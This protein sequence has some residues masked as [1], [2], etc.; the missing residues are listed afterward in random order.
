MTAKLD[1][2]IRA[3]LWHE[4]FCAERSSLKIP[5][6]LLSGISDESFYSE[7][8]DAFSSWSLGLLQPQGHFL[9][10]SSLSKR[11][12]RGPPIGCRGLA[13]P[14]SESTGPSLYTI[15]DMFPD[16]RQGPNPMFPG[17]R[18]IPPHPLSTERRK[19]MPQQCDNCP[20]ET[21]AF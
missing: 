15:V 3:G 1:L 14:N 17:C 8:G 11:S 12:L 6:P 5:S 4:V 16:L 2:L 9:E 18:P 10:F 7:V 19:E 21:F 20:Q 13:S